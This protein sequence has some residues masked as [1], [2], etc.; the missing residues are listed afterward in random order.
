MKSMVDVMM[1]EQINQFFKQQGI[2][3]SLHKIAGCASC[4]LRLQRNGKKYDEN[5]LLSII[6]EFLASKWLVASYAVDDSTHLYIDSKF[7][8]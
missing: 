5:D 7:S 8:L 1:V 3:Y 6:N 2:E 4:G